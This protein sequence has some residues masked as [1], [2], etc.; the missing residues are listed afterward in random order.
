MT[1]AP[2]GRDDAHPLLLLHGALGCAAQV[3]PLGKRLRDLLPHGREVAEMDFG[4]HGSR[5]PEG[6]VFDIA[7]FTRDVTVFLCARGIGRADIFGYSMG[8]YVALSL[9]R[10]S[11][12]LVGRIMTLGTKFAWDASTAAKEAGRLDPAAIESKLPAFAE[13]LRSWHGDAWPGVVR[14]TAGMMFGLGREPALD[15][16]D[17]RAVRHRVLAAVG[18]RD[19]MV[20]VEETH[21]V[22]RWLPAGE[23]LVLPRTPHPLDQVDTAMLADQAR[24]YFS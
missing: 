6:G 16:A 15:V 4:G 22:S 24:A 3:R 10:E 21:A 7:R 18:D 5:S 20:S 19:A 2:P 14:A 12:D 23:C 1:Q 17:I 9:A 11:P 8:G 13:R